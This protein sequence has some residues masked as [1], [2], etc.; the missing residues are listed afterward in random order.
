MS[1]TGCGVEYWLVIV[2]NETSCW[3]EYQGGTEL[4]AAMP[5]TPKDWAVTLLMFT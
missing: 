4:Y 1:M 2:L 5:P 3:V